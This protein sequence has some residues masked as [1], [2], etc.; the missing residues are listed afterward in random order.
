LKIA[1]KCE[2]ARWKGLKVRGASPM[3][4]SAMLGFLSDQRAPVGRDGGLLTL[5]SELTDA[6]AD[7][8]QLVVGGQPTELEWRA[9]CDYLRALQRLGYETLARH[10]Q[11]STA[12]HVG[13]DLVSG[14]IAA[15]NRSWEAAP[16][17]VELR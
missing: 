9:H 11:H 15:R 6:H 12:P 4:F 3:L 10:D 2:D 5:L 13:L 17:A 7:T 8:V 1:A 14:L 16:F